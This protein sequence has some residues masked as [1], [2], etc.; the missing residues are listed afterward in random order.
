MLAKLFSVGVLGIDGYPV[1]VEV[2]ITDGLPSFSIVGLPDAAIRESVDRVRSAL[3]NSGFLFPLKRITVNLAPCDVKKEGPSF[4]LPIALG[5]LQATGQL[6]A[7]TLSEYVFCGELSLDGA[8]RPISGVLP[9]AASVG[10][11]PQKNFVVPSGN[12]REAAIVQDISV[13]ALGTLMETVR[14]LRGE[15][16]CRKVHVNVETLWKENGAFKGL[17]FR[18]VRGQV[19][20]KRALEVAAAG[21]HHILLVGPPGAGKTMLAKRLPTILFRLTLEEA[22]ETTKIHSVCGF[23]TQ[24]RH[25]VTTRPFRA[26]H[27][28]ISDAGLVGGTAHP[29]PG[30]VSLAHRGVLFLDEL[31]EFKRHVL[32]VL[33]QPLEE[34]Y[35]TIARAE[36]SITYPA[37][38]ILICAMNPCPCGHLTDP[39][40]ACRC[41]PAQIEQYRS[42]VSGPLLDR[43]DIHLDIPPLK[44]EEMVQ[45][46][47]GETSEA[48]RQRVFAARLRQKQRYRDQTSHFCNAL[49]TPQEVADYCVPSAEGQELLR[50]AIQELGLS[51]RSYDRVLKVARTI[52]DLEGSETVQTH[53]VSE[54]VGYR[55][56]D[57]SFG[58][59]P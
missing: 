32:E 37:R 10:K 18:D 2:D 16:K 23:L 54:A 14:F 56:F 31:P 58:K 55:N 40:I 22:I 9:R 52:A 11:G 43:I 7:E 28:T 50:L 20:A 6:S 13:Y 34:G 57:R 17:D 15:L 25:F 46:G 39:K 24:K 49:L 3:K 45:E 38:F 44:Y 59:L 5:V 51:M 36:S 48:I 53:H 8:L 4:D 42:R 29:K 41:S 47:N 35:V 12:G 19:Y 33:R 30:E 27:H 1:D 21:G 26:P